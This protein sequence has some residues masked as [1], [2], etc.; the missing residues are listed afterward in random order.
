MKLVTVP[1]ILFS[2]FS[3]TD[4]NSDFSV[5]GI[6]SWSSH[7]TATI[8]ECSSKKQYQLGVM[9]SNPYFDLLNKSDEL[10]HNGTIQLRLKV[11]GNLEQSTSLIINSPRVL[12]LVV[13][14]CF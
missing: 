8:T 4:R 5:E 9:A 13:D 14:D 7:G 12:S 6:L 11:A 3:C 10:S 2:L 1:L